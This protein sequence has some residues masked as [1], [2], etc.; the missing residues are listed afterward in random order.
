MNQPCRLFKTVYYPT[1][2]M[3][4]LIWHIF[5]TFSKIIV[6][7][8]CTAY[9]LCLPVRMVPFFFTTHFERGSGERSRNSK[10]IVISV[11]DI[12]FYDLLCG[13]IL[14]L[15]HVL[16]P[17]CEIIKI[18]KWNVWFIKNQF[19]LILYSC[20][21]TGYVFSKEHSWPCYVL[22]SSLVFYIFHLFIFTGVYFIKHPVR[23]K[24]VVCLK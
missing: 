23:K 4:P 9:S 17:R 6:N 3:Y 16:S 24:V 22:Y 12:T 18:M 5:V 15:L 19:H 7:I 2:C 10:S 1:T 8:F 11:D 21:G 13:H 20:V 14:W